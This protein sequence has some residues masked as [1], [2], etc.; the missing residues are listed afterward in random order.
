MEHR[1]VRFF[2]FALANSL[3]FQ[4]NNLLT[5]S[6]YSIE[7]YDKIL[8]VCTHRDMIY[9][10]IMLQ[11]FASGVSAKLHN[12]QLQTLNTRGSHI[13]NVR[14]IKIRNDFIGECY[15]VVRIIKMNL[16]TYY[17]WSFEYKYVRAVKQY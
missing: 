11:I 9:L 5:S 4:Y 7:L 10:P 17:D 8:V 3:A 16:C 15:D 2:R 13:A 12:K 1:N 6:P 14:I